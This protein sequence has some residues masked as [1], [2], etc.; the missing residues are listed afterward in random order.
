[1]GGKSGL[2]WK[3]DYRKIGSEK[4]ENRTNGHGRLRTSAEKET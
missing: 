2:L 4:R 3:V 1:V